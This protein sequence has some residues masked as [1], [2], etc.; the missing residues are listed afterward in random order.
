MNLF[1]SCNGGMEN[2]INTKRFSVSHLFSEEKTQKIHI[3]DCFEVYYS[4]SG[5]KQFFIDNRYYTVSPGDVFVINQYESHY[6]SSLNQ[7]SHE[8]INIAIHPEFLSSLSTEQTRLDTCFTYR[9]ENISHRIPLDDIHQ[10]RLHY[11]LHK[12]TSTSGYGSDILENAA[13][14]ELMAMINY[15][16]SKNYQKHIPF[17]STGGHSQMIIDIMEYIN[18]NITKDIHVHSIAETFYISESYLCRIF[19]TYTGTTINKY[20]TAR[21]IGI[22][23]SLLAGGNSVSEVYGMVGFNDYSSFLK[24]F[25]KLVGI[26]P[27]KY[28]KFN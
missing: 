7:T 5:G 10:Q 16:F 13:F 23:K 9:T 15:Q 6:I 11:Y 18:K 24:A 2:C 22:A 28:T 19:K 8:R 4:I 21:R 27:K 12:I 20:I 17:S 25:V 14:S 3:H 26:S 1:F